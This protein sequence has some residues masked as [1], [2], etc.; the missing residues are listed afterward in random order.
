MKKSIHPPQQQQQKPPE[1]KNFSV[2]YI[3][4]TPKNHAPGLVS[5]LRSAPSPPHAPELSAHNKH[6]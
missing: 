5:V 3:F 2:K 4:Y 1:Y 6:S